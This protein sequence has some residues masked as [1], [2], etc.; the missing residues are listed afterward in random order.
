M[1]L[2]DI[3]GIGPAYAQKLAMAGIRTPQALLEKGYTRAMR[4]KLAEETGIDQ[5]LILEWVNM[6]DLF[7]IEGLGVAYV[8]LLE[9]VG[10]DSSK[11]LSLRQAEQLLEAMKRT[12]A[13]KKL[14]RKLPSLDQI[15]KAITIATEIQYHGH[16]LAGNET[17]DAPP[18]KKGKKKIKRYFPIVEY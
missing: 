13:R 12:N 7:R 17:T 8:D 9:E 15:T 1:K 6:A 16:S 3:E 5:K 10:V 11:E 14:T 4:H 2:A 18:P